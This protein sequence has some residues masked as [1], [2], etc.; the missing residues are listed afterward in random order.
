ML[1]AALRRVV[2]LGVSPSVLTGRVAILRALGRLPRARTATREPIR[3]ILFSFPYHSVG[4]LILS[5]SLLDHVHEQWP[6]AQI[7]VAVGAS[8]GAVVETIPYVRRT[9]KLKRAKIQQPR[10]AA[11][12]EIHNETELFRAE[13]A[14]TQYDLAIAP[15]WD[16][17]DSVFSGYLA[18]L[19]GAPI[20]CGYSGTSDGGSSAV[21]RFYTVAAVGGAGEHESFRYTRLL[22]RCGFE[23]AEAV[24]PAMSEKPIRALQAIA[25]QRKACGKSLAPPVA[26]SYAVFSPGATNARRKW[27]LDR[28]GEVGRALNQKY[29]LKSIVIGGPSDAGLCEELR[30]AIGESALSLAGKTDTLQLLDL[31][32]GT[33]L[34]LGN[35]SG[36]SHIAGGLGRNTIVISPFPLKCTDDHPN[37]P[38]RFRPVGPRVR[39]LRPESPLEPCSPTCGQESAHCILQITSAQVLESVEESIA[40]SICAGMSEMEGVGDGTVSSGERD[41]R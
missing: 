13:I 4:D 9:F 37:S 2:T 11:Y 39:V 29:G 21:D 24:D 7:D 23:R 5:L 10:L 15:R 3:Q 19:T 31:I 28:F 25:K 41:G 33:T 35:D 27:P 34:F 17:A 30:K 20:R 1:R 38:Q 14:E 36:P 16:S 22:S 8:M 26:G 32:D 40:E 6:E 12:A 18:Y